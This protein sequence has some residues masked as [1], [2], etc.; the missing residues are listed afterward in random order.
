MK[1]IKTNLV[2]KCAMVLVVILFATSFAGCG[3]FSW[4]EEDAVKYVR[5][6]LDTATKGDVKEYAELTKVTEKEA[7]AE[8]DTLVDAEVASFAAAGLS[9]KNTDQLK[10]LVVALYK[11]LKYQVKSA[12]KD[13]E[14]FI[15]TVEVQPFKGLATLEA[16]VQALATQEAAE[17]ANIDLTSTEAITEWQLGLFLDVLKENVENPE[18][19]P[20]KEVKVHITK[21]DKQYDLAD[22]E[23]N[24]LMSELLGVE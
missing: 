7:K 22:D 14:G 8:Y 15:V 2:K 23:I 9:G 20:A 3:L 21:T 24:N 17:A 16:D 11:D 10:G 12:K 4:K 13:G 6:T 18:Y 5:A 19:E 1:A